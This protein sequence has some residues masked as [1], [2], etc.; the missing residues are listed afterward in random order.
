MFTVPVT[1][2]EH[3]TRSWTDDIRNAES[4]YSVAVFVA[5]ACFVQYLQPVSGMKHSTKHGGPHTVHFFYR[6]TGYSSCQG[7]SLRMEASCNINLLAQCKT[8]G[9]SGILSCKI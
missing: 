1:K 3:S 9:L 2:P 6:C 7:V 4:V 8:K 5:V